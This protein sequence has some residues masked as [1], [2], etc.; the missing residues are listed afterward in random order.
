M[1]KNTIL[2]SLEDLENKL[3]K[4][5]SA[6]EMVKKTV[7]AHQEVLENLKIYSTVLDNITTNIK[8]IVTAIQKT[9]KDYLNSINESLESKI[10]NLNQFSFQFH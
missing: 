4:I 3:P 1:D 5:I 8:N 7:S 6:A 2:E 9:N 10:S